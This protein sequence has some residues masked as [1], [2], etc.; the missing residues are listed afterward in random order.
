M[1]KKKTLERFIEESR[2]VHGDK[3]DYSKVEYIN[4]YTKVCIICPTHGEFW[5]T[6]HDHKTC[7]AG[8]P[9]CNNSQKSNKIY[10][11]GINDIY[12]AT[13]HKNKPYY[14]WRCVLRRC[15]DVDTLKKHPTYLGCKVSNEWLN[16][17]SFLRWFDEHYVE[18][19]HLDKD[20]LVKGN[21]VYSPETCCFV[22]QEIN[23]L[24]TTRRLC[25]G[26][27]LVG[28]VKFK[29]GKYHSAL[30]INKKI[31]H[32]GCFKT[33]MD[34]FFAYKKAKEDYIK[35]VAYKWKDMLESRV[36]EALL[37]YKVEITD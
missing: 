23:K 25:R 36:Y 28:V 1:P 16:F 22:P 9:F 29:N 12:N 20:I 10:G 34:A 7:G 8:C 2:K 11:C 24:F 14:I 27:Y 30:S 5:Q 6:P 15:Y 19:Y 35:S 32:L 31:T 33:E 3:Y 13:I 4:S 26:K 37:N 21:K 18:G 17:S